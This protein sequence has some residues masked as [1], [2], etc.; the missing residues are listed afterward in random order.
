MELCFKQPYVLVLGSVESG[1][2]YNGRSVEGNSVEISSVREVRA[3]V[4]GGGRGGRS[5]LEVDDDALEK[6]RDNIAVEFVDW[7]RERTPLRVSDKAGSSN[8]RVESRANDPRMWADAELDLRLRVECASLPGASCP[9]QFA[10][11]SPYESGTRGLP[12]APRTSP[13]GE[14]VIKRRDSLGVAERVRGG[15]GVGTESSSKELNVM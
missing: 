5:V 12:N 6:F 15:V 11:G 7:F 4:G 1:S 13:R 2:L 14:G 9:S 3:S 10:Y 8:D